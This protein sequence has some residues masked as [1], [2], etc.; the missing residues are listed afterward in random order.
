[1][2]REDGFSLVELVV[3]MAVFGIILALAFRFLITVTDTTAA[4][5]TSTAV[6]S[7]L[8]LALRTISEDV[9]AATAISPSCPA[10]GTAPASYA[11]CLQFTVDHD[12]NPTDLCPRSVITYWLATATVNGKSIGTV[13]ESSTNYAGTPDACTASTGYNNLPVITALGNGSTPLFTYADSFGNPLAVS[14]ASPSPVTAFQRAASVTVTL[15][16][17]PGGK[18][19]P[20]ELATTVALRNNR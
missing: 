13:Y 12:P 14:G 6:Q 10:G 18:V 17:D 8:E 15:V 1:M 9:R 4:A 11:T 5:Q 7:Q 3:V 20:T 19:A 2:R 16:D